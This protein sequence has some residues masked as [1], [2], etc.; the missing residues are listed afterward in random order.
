[1]P[2][3]PFDALKAHAARLIEHGRAIRL[4]MLIERKAR[5]GARKE[6]RQ[7]RLALAER[8]R[9]KII[10]IQFQQVKGIQ[11]ALAEPAAAME[12][13]IFTLLMQLDAE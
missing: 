12:L 2:S 7:P 3:R 4:D 11:E 6:S 9:S 13:R 10:A 1:M 5:G 8:Q